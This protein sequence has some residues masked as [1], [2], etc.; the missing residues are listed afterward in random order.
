MGY[1]SDVTY[2]FY[3]MN[4]DVVPFAAIK[5]WFDENFTKN[6]SY[7][8]NIE[9]GDDWIMVSWN[10][11]K[12]YDDFDEVEATREATALF[13]E[14]FEADTK[15]HVAWEMVEVG[16]D[17]NDIKHDGSMNCNYRLYVNRTIHFE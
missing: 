8:D 3:T 13:A 17:L 1:R 9:V 11:V 7:Y 12:W 4:P 15:E 16:E 14:V 10:S 2:V 5:L 6:V